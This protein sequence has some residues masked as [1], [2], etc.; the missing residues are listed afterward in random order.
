MK[1]KTHLHYTLVK[2]QMLDT[3]SW[4]KSPLQRNMCINYS[5]P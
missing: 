2:A 5:H 4:C 3:A 1:K